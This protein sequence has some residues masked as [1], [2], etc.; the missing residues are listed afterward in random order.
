MFL[1]DLGESGLGV[2]FDSIWWFSDDLEGFLE[3][4]QREVVCGLSGQ[5][6]SEVL[7]RFLH[8]FELFLQT[9]L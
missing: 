5:P 2:E 4:T 3:Q 1:G 6:Q 9:G 8:Q 7:V